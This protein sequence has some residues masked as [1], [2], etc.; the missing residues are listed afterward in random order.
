MRKS[1]SQNNLLCFEY[2]ILNTNE[3]GLSFL[4]VKVSVL[5]ISNTFQFMSKGRYQ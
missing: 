3:D 4:P 5:P 1:G 2:V